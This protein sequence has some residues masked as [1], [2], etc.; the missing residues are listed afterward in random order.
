MRQSFRVLRPTH[1]TLRALNYEPRVERLRSRGNDTVALVDLL[2]KVGESYGSIFFAAECDP[3]Y[4]VEL[5]SQRAMFRAEPQGKWIRRDS[6][7]TPESHVIH[8]WQVLIA[9]TGTLAPTELY[10]RSILADERLAGKYLGP[11]GLAL[12]F[13]DHGSDVSL[14]T[15]AFLLTELGLA[16]I[17]SLSAGTKL[18][19]PRLD[20][21][22]KLRVPVANGAVMRRVAALIRRCADERERY[23]HELESATNDLALVE[24]RLKEAAAL[25]GRGAWRTEI[26]AATSIAA[27]NHRPAARAFP[28]GTAVAALIQGGAPHKANRF[29]RTP[30]APGY[31]S[32]F[33]GQRDLFLIRPIPQFIRPPTS[34]LG[35]VAKPGSIIVA[36]AGQSSESTLFGRCELGDCFD[37]SLVSEHTLHLMV[38]TRQIDHRYF[39]A[40]LRS[41]WGMGALKGCATGTS[42]PSL[43]PMLLSALCIPRLTDDQESGV[44]RHI[45][46]AYAARAEAGRC[47]AEAIRIVEQ[48]VLPAWLA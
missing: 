2:S 44:A 48:E 9:G 14:Y 6:L 13:K 35:L 46:R 43:D 23:L 33:L 27:R 42:V 38:D 26:T 40:V 37:G 5:L 19:R 8:K 16:A 15:Y 7:P 34:L 28:R 20:M 32:P 30:C 24:P 4:G 25:Y 21:L 29:A 10:G 31:G 17:R 3:G 36:A 11:D 39:F 1:D 45:E 47:E 12:T 41:P 18:L 22:V